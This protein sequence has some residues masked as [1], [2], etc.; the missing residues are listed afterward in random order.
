MWK[1]L[2]NIYDISSD[3]I[4]QMKLFL[5]KSRTELADRIGTERIADGDFR[6]KIL[7]YF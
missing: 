6:R 2:S 4:V 7:E 3:Q 5:Q 1:L